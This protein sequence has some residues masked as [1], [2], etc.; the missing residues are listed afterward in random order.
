MNAVQLLLPDHRESGVWFCTKCRLAYSSEPS[1]SRCCN[2]PACTDCGKEHDAPGL[3]CRSCFDLRQE[4]REAE[5]FAK[6]KKVPM[7]EYSGWL[8][9]DGTGGYITD[10]YHENADDLITYCKDNGEP[11]PEYAWACTPTQ[12][13][14]ADIGRIIESICEDAY[15]DFNPD[16]LVGVDKLEAAIN[17]FNEANKHHLSYSP[18]YSTAVLLP[19]SPK[20]EDE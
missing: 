6:A 11:V 2:K 8:Q 16:D 7:E 13:A 5:R 17:E 4:K 9:R 3:Q 19:A 10:G 20:D 1:A 14:T 15:E 12:F 18:D